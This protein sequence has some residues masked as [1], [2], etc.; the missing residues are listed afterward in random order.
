MNLVIV[1]ICAFIFA[2]ML[3]LLASM[4]MDIQQTKKEAQMQIEKVEKLR[5]KVEKERQKENE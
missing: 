4:Y 1:I 3:P 2:L 5:R